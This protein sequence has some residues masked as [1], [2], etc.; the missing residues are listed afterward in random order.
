MKLVRRL[1]LCLALVAAQAAASP[2]EDGVA[3]YDRGEYGA[4]VTLWRRL[5]EQGH[6]AAQFNLAVL[7]EKGLGV[8]QDFA[9]AARWYL[10]AA[11]QGDQEAQYNVAALYES[12]TGFPTDLDQAR[13]WYVAAIANRAADTASATIRQ[14]AR[15]R[16]DQIL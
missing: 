5:A 8:G 10:K 9:E 14:R 4:A 11:E 15:E 13:K 3:A 2:Y 16:L 6:R 7:Y 12:G 1:V